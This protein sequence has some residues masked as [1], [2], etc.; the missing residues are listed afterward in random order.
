MKPFLLFEQYSDKASEKILCRDNL[1][2]DLN[3]NYIF[4][5]MS[6]GDTFLYD[7]AKSVIF[8]IINQIMQE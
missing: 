6:Q 2:K 8:N 5:T 1:L 4:K 7:T 3:L